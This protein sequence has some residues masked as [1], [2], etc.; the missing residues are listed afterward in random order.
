MCEELSWF[1]V[2]RGKNKVG[3]QPVL[4]V[5]NAVPRYSVPDAGCVNDV[6]YQSTYNVVPG[7]L[8]LERAGD[9]RARG[10]ERPLR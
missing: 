2:R 7:Y 3:R 8:P 6:D 1:G 10:Q 5:S 9:V 4:P